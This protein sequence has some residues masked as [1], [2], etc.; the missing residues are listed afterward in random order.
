MRF[1]LFQYLS[2]DFVNFLTYIRF[3][4]V[5]CCFFVSY[6][7]S[8]VISG[9]FTG[10]NATTSAILSVFSRLSSRFPLAFYP[11]LIFM[12]KPQLFCHPV[13]FAGIAGESAALAD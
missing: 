11:S 12:L 3:L 13:F 10:R 2:T 9:P 1:P 8:P 6:A 4:L 5:G 7:Q